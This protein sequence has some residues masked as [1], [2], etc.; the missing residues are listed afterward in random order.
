MNSFWQDVRYGLQT[1]VKNPGFTI[2]AVISLAL[3]IGVNTTMFS[4]LDAVMLRSLPVQ[5]PEQIVDIATRESGGDPHRDFSYPLYAGLRDH[6]DVLSGMIAYV[7]VSVGLTAGDQTE[8][9]NA[10]FVSA[11][12]FSVLG[13]QPAFGS[14]F[15][16][17]DERPGAP[18]AA[19]ISYALWKRRLSGD[20]AAL[21]KTIALNGRTFSIVGVAPRN[22]SGL[23]RGAPTD[24]WLTLPHRV[25]F[26]S[27]PR[28][29]TSDQVSWLSLAGRL[30]PGVTIEQAQARLT[31]LLPGVSEEA[32]QSGKWEAAL[33]TASG[34]SQVYVAELTRPL[35]LLFIAVLLILAIACANVASLLLARA[36]S[37]GKEIG[38]RLALGATRPRIVRRSEEHTSELQ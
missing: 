1:L 18:R 11:N 34:G 28:L 12:Y 3:G 15:A 37:R 17:D 35:K 38:I 27:D 7:D 31:S 25:D 23:L 24:V 33:T 20:P 10:E 21:Q 2:I 14:A 5:H 19:V 9:I 22:Y 36:K 30:K 32:R 29:L 13:I 4:L 8:R 6:N 16:A 26:E